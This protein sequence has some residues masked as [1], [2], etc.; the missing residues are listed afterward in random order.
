MLSF[1]KV[2]DIPAVSANFRNSLAQAGRS[3]RKLEPYWGGAS[4]MA[5]TVDRSGSALL[6]SLGEAFGDVIRKDYDR[7]LTQE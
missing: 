1:W 4:N 7:E 2:K 3:W 5:A 6:S